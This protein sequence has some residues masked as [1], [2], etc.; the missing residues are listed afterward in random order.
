MIDLI[1]DHVTKFYKTTGE[2]DVTN[3]LCHFCNDAQN[4]K[5]SQE[6]DLV[7]YNLIEL[8][9]NC[10]SIIG[11][12]VLQQPHKFKLTIENNKLTFNDL[13]QTVEQ[14]LINEK[15]FVEILGLTSYI[16]PN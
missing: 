13:G 8:N 4:V 1:K 5:N 16:F 6:P 3:W 2:F 14:P 10:L 15:K 12:N 9:K 7:N 11:G